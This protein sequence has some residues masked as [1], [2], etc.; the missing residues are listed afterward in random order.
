MLPEPKII[1]SL[2]EGLI[3]GKSE[4][5]IFVFR[6]G[7]PIKGFHTDIKDC[8]PIIEEEAQRYRRQLEGE[9][10]SRTYSV[11]VIHSGYGVYDGDTLVQP[12]VTSNEQFLPLVRT[13]AENYA[14]R[15]QQDNPS[16]RYAVKEF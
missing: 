7:V 5:E 14:K 6:D 4:H 16:G 10:S 13:E 15:L 8:L 3:L 2:E 12:F 11:G 9:D 1:G